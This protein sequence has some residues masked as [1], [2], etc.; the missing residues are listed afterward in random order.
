MPKNDIK[1]FSVNILEICYVVKI[2][3]LTKT[4][5]MGKPVSRKKYNQELE[6]I[7][8]NLEERINKPVKLDAKNI[9]FDS[10]KNGYTDILE[11][12]I[13]LNKEVF[14]EKLQ[15]RT[16]LEAAVESHEKY[17]VQFLLYNKVQVSDIARDKT[18]GSI[19]SYAIYKGYKDIAKLLIEY[20]KEGD[21]KVKDSKGIT[22]FG[23]AIQTGQYDLLD[24]FLRNEYFL[25]QIQNDKSDDLLKKLAFTPQLNN[26]L[27][28]L[29]DAGANPNNYDDERKLPIHWAAM[30]GNIEAVQILSAQTEGGINVKNSRTKLTPLHYYAISEKPILEN[31]VLFA[32]LGANFNAKDKKGNT[33]LSAITSFCSKDIVE[34]T[35]KYVDA[36]DIQNLNKALFSTMTY[37][38]IEVAEVLIKYTENFEPDSKY[39]FLNTNSEK[40]N[41]ETPLLQSLRPQYVLTQKGTASFDLLKKLGFINVKESSKSCTMYK[42]NNDKI[43]YKLIEAGVNVNIPDKDGL[44]PITD[45]IIRN[46]F[47]M[48][49]TLRNA[50]ADITIINNDGHNLLHYVSF[51]GRTEMLESLLARFLESGINI[52]LSNPQDISP[53]HLAAEAGHLEIVKLLVQ[54]N[55][56][57]NKNTLLDWA[58]VGGYEEVIEYLKKEKLV[59][60]ETPIK[61]VYPLKAETPRIVEDFQTEPAIEPRNLTFNRSNGAEELKVNDSIAG[62][63]KDF[64]S[65]FKKLCKKIEN[66]TEEEPV[67]RW[68]IGKTIYTNEDVHEIVDRFGNIVYAVISDKVNCKGDKRLLQKFNDAIDHGFIGS[69][70]KIGIKPI[71][72]DGKLKLYEICIPNV[73]TRVISTVE[74]EDQYGKRLMFFNMEPD[75]TGVKTLAS[76]IKGF[77]T[78]KSQEV[79]QE[80]FLKIKQLTVKSEEEF[81]P[82]SENTY[83]PVP[84]YDDYKEGMPPPSDDVESTGLNG[85]Y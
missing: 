59:P 17:C 71:R 23:Y 76:R 1:I 30:H 8:K 11:K 20:S 2:N 14:K 70:G 60:E 75:H 45:A 84:D 69:E 37:D 53:I 42:K 54:N 80:D 56:E 13:T 73:N 48:F 33:C 82:A 6:K 50:G 26:V 43:A 83:L 57:Y 77:S 22:P 3:F 41:K 81:A 35:L 67:H 10:I 24:E 64:H 49:E 15:G 47:K 28:K 38:N 85:L 51:F 36:S 7:R 16:T 12:V 63:I 32:K 40:H 34:E 68:K 52:N 39:A 79:T 25:K 4:R 44:Y 66:D 55:V 78:E 61:A 31:I 58:T 19:I 65:K 46:N 27:Q 21:F 72:I 62:Q 18:Y 9:V 5:F 74:Y 29:L